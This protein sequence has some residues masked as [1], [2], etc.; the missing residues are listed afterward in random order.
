MFKRYDVK[1]NKMK[2]VESNI[3]DQSPLRRPDY[4]KEH[5]ADSVIMALQPLLDE[6]QHRLRAENKKLK[7]KFQLIENNIFEL[8]NRVNNRVTEYEKEKAIRQL[9]VLI[10]KAIQNGSIY[11]GTLS[12]EISEFLSNVQEF[13]LTQLDTLTKK[14]IELKHSR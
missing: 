8:R 10:Q 12:S 14:L 9:L 6:N 4:Q 13:N 1:V 11:T 2:V 3:V 7:I 5:F